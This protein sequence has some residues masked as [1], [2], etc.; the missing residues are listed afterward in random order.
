L[1]ERSEARPGRAAELAVLVAA[2]AAATVLRFVLLRS[3]VF[4]PRRT[5]T[6]TKES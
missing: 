4:H 5:P 3:W 6:T 2:N 1:L